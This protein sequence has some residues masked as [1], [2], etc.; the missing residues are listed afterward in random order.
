MCSVP[1][2]FIWK[3]EKIRASSP[4]SIALKERKQEMAR[5]VEEQRRRRE[6]GAENENISSD[7]T[8]LQRI[9]EKEEV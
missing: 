2:I 8:I 6:R 7:S 5:K 4:F 1:F 3:G 9:E